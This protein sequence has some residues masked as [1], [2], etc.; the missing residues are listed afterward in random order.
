VRGSLGDLISDPV[1]SVLT[2][3]RVTVAQLDIQWMC[4][5]K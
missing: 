4:I 2:L 1:G 3:Y 5:K